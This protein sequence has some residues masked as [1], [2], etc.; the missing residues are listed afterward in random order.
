MK[1]AVLVFWKWVNDMT[2][3]VLLAWLG[4]H[5]VLIMMFGAVLYVLL[6]LSVMK[7]LQDG[8]GWFTE[9][10]GWTPGEKK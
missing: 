7:K 1:E 8:W 9:K 5:F 2:N 10:I 6:P 4:D 3:P